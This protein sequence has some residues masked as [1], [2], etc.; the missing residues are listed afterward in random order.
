MQSCK[1]CA[2]SKEENVLA[3]LM[4]NYFK[5]KKVSFVQVAPSY[6]PPFRVFL[7]INFSLNF[8]RIFPF[9]SKQTCVFAINKWSPKLTL[10]PL[11]FSLIFIVYFLNFKN[12]NLT[13]SIKSFVFH[14]NICE[15]FK[16]L[17]CT[18]LLPFNLTSGQLKGNQS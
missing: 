18:V 5:L 7:C 2:R 10:Q 15:K 16:F 13:L 17:L 6:S 14:F 8:C 12:L 9:Y 3:V 4:N 11:I 1:F